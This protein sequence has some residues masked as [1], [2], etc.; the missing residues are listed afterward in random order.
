MAVGLQTIVARLVGGIP[1]PILY[2]YFIDDTCI[3]WQPST[4]G[5]SGIFFSILDILDIRI[6]IFFC[7]IIPPLAPV[8]CTT[9]TG[10]QW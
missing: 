9:T 2:G 1:G 7:Q 4:C 6:E 5:K 10:S 8:W 3:L